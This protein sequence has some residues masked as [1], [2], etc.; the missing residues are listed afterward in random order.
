MKLSVRI[1]LFIFALNLVSMGIS[2]YLKADIGIGSWDVLNN[3]LAQFYR[4]SFGTWVFIVGII[5]ILVSQLL[6]FRL[7]NFLAIIPGLIMGFLIDMWLIIFHFQLDNIYLQF[8]IFF[9]ALILLGSG[10]SLLVLT[11][12]PPTPADILMLSLMKCFKTNFF[13]ARTTTDALALISGIIVG[14]INNKPLNNIGIG[15]LL[16]LLF[17]GSIV[18]VTS[19]FWKKLLKQV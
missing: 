1:F 5:T 14:A 11:K 9:L 12:L 16:A 7:Y 17:V 2:L 6:Y 3:N 13:V 10:I 4:F 8:I 19:R 18:Q 15:T